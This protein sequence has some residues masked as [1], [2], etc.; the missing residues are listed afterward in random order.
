MTAEPGAG[1]RVYGEPS[2]VKR[3]TG[4]PEAGSIVYPSVGLAA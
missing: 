2:E 3:G 4:G 1:C